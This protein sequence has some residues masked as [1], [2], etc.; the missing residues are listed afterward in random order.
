MHLLIFGPQ[1]SGK[2]TQS[3]LLEQ[4][5]GFTHIS[6][7]D[8]LRKEARLGTAIGKRIQQMMDRGEIVSEEITERLLRDALKGAKRGFILDGFPRTVTQAAFIEAHTRIDAVILL[9]IPETL[10]LE[11][12]HG[13]VQC[14][15]G[16]GFHRTLHTAKREGICDHC[17]LPLVP[18]SDDTTVAVMRRLE[19]YR[20]E[21]VP[22]L[23]R[24]K[25]KIIHIDATSTVIDVHH[26]IMR[27][28]RRFKTKGL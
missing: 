11:R 10:A 21:T 26:A 3:Y 15:N 28:L 12:I 19:T 22:L 1:G 2:G 8:L 7:G 5:Y 13:R 20:R 27:E 23:E 6:T 17:G 4:E 16:H 18:R 14:A 25:D 9:D 24:Y